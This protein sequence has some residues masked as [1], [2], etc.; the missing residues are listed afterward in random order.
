[1]KKMLGAGSYYSD[2]GTVTAIPKERFH[3]TATK[4]LMDIL[5]A[6]IGLLVAMPVFAVIAAAI[7]LEDRSG[8]I[9]FHQVRVGK[10]GV[11]FKMHKF[12]SM[13]S[14]AEQQLGELLNQ[15]EIDGPMFKMKN[16]PR[17]TR[18]GRWIRKT[19]LDELPQLWN[20]LKG[21]MS[22]VGPRPPLPRE[23]ERYT[24]YDKQRLEVIP[25]CTGLWQISGRNHLSFY[26]MVELDLHYIR[27]R[28]VWWDIK[29][30]MFTVTM[31][32]GSKNAY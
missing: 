20:V 22:L 7:K 31:L 8:P 25:G 29:I 2:R 12:R 27:H 30:M 10:N 23:V 16:D 13:V 15:N 3:Y 26:D 19:S 4:R 21:E 32:L 11:P 24:L 18:I 1:M 6:V 14:N 17:M 5:G 28:S 9:F